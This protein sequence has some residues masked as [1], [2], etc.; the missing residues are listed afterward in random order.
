MVSS[1]LDSYAARKTGKMSGRM[2]GLWRDPVARPTHRKHYASPYSAYERD[3]EG[4]ALPFYYVMRKVPNVGYK[5]RWEEDGTPYEI[6]RVW[7]MVDDDGEP[8]GQGRFAMAQRVEKWFKTAE[9]AKGH[10][11]RLF[12]R[13][14]AGSR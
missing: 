14:I 11:E 3:K 4:L 1:I 8:S 6:R 10:L 5:A 2:I 9:E 12:A 13:K 7:L